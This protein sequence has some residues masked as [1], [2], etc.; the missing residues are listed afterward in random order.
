VADPLN[1]GRSLAAAPTPAGG[2]HV[3][4]PFGQN[5]TFTP[6]IVQKTFVIA[7]GIGQAAAPNGVTPETI[8]GVVATPV[9]ASANLGGLTA[10][11]RQYAPAQ[12]DGHFVVFQDAIAKRDAARFL[13]DVTSN[14]TPQVGR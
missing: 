2:K 13:A 3:F 12:Y 5:D 7:S 6:S 10:F 11:A 14:T 4:V 1:H 9:P 8:E